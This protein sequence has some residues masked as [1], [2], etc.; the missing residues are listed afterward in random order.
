MYQQIFEEA[1]QI[2]AEREKQIDQLEAERKK[3]QTKADEA[4]N[5]KAA[6]E[7]KADGKAYAA[8][9]ADLREQQDIIQMYNKKITNLNSQPLINET[10]YELYKRKLFRYLDKINQESKAKL[11]AVIE[12]MAKERD[13]L[14]NEYNKVNALVHKLQR[15]MAKQGDIKII[16]RPDGRTEKRLVGDDAYLRMDLVYFYNQVLSNKSVLEAKG[17]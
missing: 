2:I 7:E 15:D 10:E 17:K 14:Q 6:A 1:Q 12:P 11:L 9:S 5:R 4:A 16:N 3:A 13:R 8:A